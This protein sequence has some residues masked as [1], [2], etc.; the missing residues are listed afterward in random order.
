M[1]NALNPLTFRVSKVCPLLCEVNGGL[2]LEKVL[3]KENL[4]VLGGQVCSSF[5]IELIEQEIGRLPCFYNSKL[6]ILILSAYARRNLLPVLLSQ[7][8]VVFASYF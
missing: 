2:E 1:S 7:E 4:S 3:Y 8:H 5:T 6:Y